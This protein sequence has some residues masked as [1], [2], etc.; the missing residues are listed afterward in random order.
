MRLLLAAEP[1]ALDIAVYHSQQAAEQAIKAWL[2]WKEVP[3]PKTHDLNRLLGLC[4][5][6]ELAVESLRPHAAFLNPFAAEFVIPATCPNAPA[7]TRSRRCASPLRCS[8]L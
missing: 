2:V 7:K 8:N 6:L 5:P 3:F 4:A 1:P